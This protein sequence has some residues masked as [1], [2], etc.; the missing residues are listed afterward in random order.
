MILFKEGCKGYFVKRDRLYFFLVK[1][2]RP[3]FI[4]VKREKQKAFPRDS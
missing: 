2:E 3:V 4:Y 1:R